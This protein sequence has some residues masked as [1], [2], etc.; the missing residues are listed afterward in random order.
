MMC[1]WSRYYVI[2]RGKLFAMDGGN[3]RCIAP[4]S[5]EGVMVKSSVLAMCCSQWLHQKHLEQVFVV[6][7]RGMFPRQTHSHC[8]SVQSL[9]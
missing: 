2:S 1:G 4:L 5:H 3:L 9:T 8:F 7:P 6:L